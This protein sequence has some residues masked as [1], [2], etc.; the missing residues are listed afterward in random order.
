MGGAAISGQNSRQ[1]EDGKNASP[2]NSGETLDQLKHRIDAV[3][4]NR[5]RQQQR[6]RR[7]GLPAE[8]AALIGRIATEMVAGLA[9]GGFIGWMLDR[10]LGTTPLFMIVLFFFGAAAGMMN[11]WRMA[12]GHGLKVGYFDQKTDKSDGND[13]TG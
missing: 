10:F 9:V 13:R 1:S 2:K 3:E 8:A 4:E 12:Q 5:D 11:I 6:N 7:A